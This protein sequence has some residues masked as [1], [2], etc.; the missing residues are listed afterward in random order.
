MKASEVYMKAAQILDSKHLQPYMGDSQA[1]CRGCCDAIQTVDGDEGSPLSAVF[2]KLFKPH[3]DV[4]VY[5]GKHWGETILGSGDYYDKDVKQ[6][7]VLG[8][9]MMSAIAEYEEEHDKCEGE[10]RKTVNDVVGEGC[11]SIHDGYYCTRLEGHDDNHI[12]CG[13]GRHNIEVWP[14]ALGVVTE[15][16]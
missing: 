12:A 3:N 14:Q 5:W 8:L 2:T 1:M 13:G 7:R 10:C 11:K 4:Y 15:E 16:L 9:L 6:C